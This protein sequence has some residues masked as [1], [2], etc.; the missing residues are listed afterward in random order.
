MTLALIIVRDPLH[1]CLHRVVHSLALCFVNYISLCCLLIECLLRSYSREQSATPHENSHSSSEQRKTS[2]LCSLLALL[3]CGCGY[4]H[5]DPT[6]RLRV[7]TVLCADIGFLFSWR[8]FS[9]QPEAHHLEKFGVLQPAFREG[10]VITR[11]LIIPSVW[12]CIL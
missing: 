10:F 11:V 5:G 4:G 12:K 9:F 3:S 8:I 2:L 1:S 6:S 7:L